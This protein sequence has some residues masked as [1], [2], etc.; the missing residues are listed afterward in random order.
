VKYWCVGNEMWG[1]W[2]L[3]FMR[4]DQY[5][6]KN[7]LVADAM[8][9]ADPNLVLV[10]SGDLG[11]GRGR[12]WSRG[13]LEHCADHMDFLSEHFYVRSTSDDI[14]RHVAQVVGAIRGKAD[15]HRRLQAELPNLAG[16][17]IPIAMDE[18]N[19]WY[20]PYEYG[21]LGCVYRL[22]DALGI[23]AGLHEYFRQS[24]LIHMAHYAQTV[25]V[26]GCVKTTK[27]GAFFDATALPLLLY[28]REFGT[29]PLAVS[30]DYADSALDVAAARTEDGSAVTIGV[31]NPTDK[32]QSLEI[33]VSGMKLASTAKVWRIT[34]EDDDPKAFNTVDQQPVAIR[35]EA[36]VPFA[37]ELIVPPYS[38]NV[39]RIATE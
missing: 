8:R 34:A 1:S 6:L 4:L 33:G 29:T 39:Y 15:G 13:M 21:E 3:G 22:R 16:R 9:K 5:V 36:S 20:E 30:G 14:P 10:A 2:Q 28:R 31:V 18:W 24:D 12:S 35:D 7:N 23:A 32:P 17:T 26:I 11:R 37:G 25:N 38:A 19:Y 27:T